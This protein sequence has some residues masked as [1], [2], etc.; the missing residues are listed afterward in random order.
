MLR[1]GSVCM[2]LIYNSLTYESKEDESS[3]LLKKR[4]RK[5]RCLSDT[6][7]NYGGVMSK[8]SQ[9]L[10]LEDQSSAVFSI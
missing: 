9:M 6:L 8:I 4:Y 1:T 3:T 10:S 2:S 7:Q 5:L